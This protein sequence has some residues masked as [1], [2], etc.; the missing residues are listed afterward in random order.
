MSE[1][2]S[3]IR[4]A[5]V[6]V[7]GALLALSYGIDLDRFVVVESPT[8]S[9]A[10]KA[11]RPVAVVS[12]SEETKE[13]WSATRHLTAR[14]NAEHH[15]KK[16]KYDF[17]Y[18]TADEYIAAATDFVQDPPAGIQTKTQADG[19]VL[20]FDP[21]SARFAVMQADGTLRTYFKL[22][23]EVHGYPSNQAYFDAQ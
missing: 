18:R 9:T 5:L 11:S 8:Q 15:F 10:K 20:L 23:P 4:F 14:E 12:K 22:N 21:S 19:D 2:F 1:T 6:L 7:M 16:H 17:N 3:G 13:I